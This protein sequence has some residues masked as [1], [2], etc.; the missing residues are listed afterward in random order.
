MLGLPV[1]LAA[2]SAFSILAL[3]ES[4]AL[5]SRGGSQKGCVVS[6]CEVVER[7]RETKRGYILYTL[8]FI[9]R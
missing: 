7:D 1:S 4:R 8:R 9:K 5:A 6:C 3:E 2:V